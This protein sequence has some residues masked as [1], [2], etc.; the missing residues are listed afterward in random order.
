MTRI[1]LLLVL[2]MGA[3][4]VPNGKLLGALSPDQAIAVC[5]EYAERTI[6]CEGASSEETFVFGG[7]CENADA[8][9]DCG[10]TVGD[11][12]ACQDAV[13][14]VSDEVFCDDLDVPE[15]CDAVRDG[16]CVL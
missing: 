3:C 15:A 7:D 12:R 9:L 5:E 8:P 13:E 2:L 14:M 1:P 10:A 4:V 16:A 11:Y 6:V